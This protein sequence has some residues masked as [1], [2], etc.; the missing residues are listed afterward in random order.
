MTAA[1]TTQAARWK[2]TEIVELLFKR[3]ANSI[4]MTCKTEAL[5]GEAREIEKE[6][7]LARTAGL[8]CLLE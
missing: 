4:G 3:K 1:G 5:I 6:S 8:V 7:T 2:S